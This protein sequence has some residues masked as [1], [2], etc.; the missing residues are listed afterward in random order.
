[1]NEEEKIELINQLNER[2]PEFERK[3]EEARQKL[4][5]NEYASEKEMKEL[6][7]WAYEGFPY[8][9]V[10]ASMKEHLDSI[11]LEEECCPEC[12]GKVVSFYFCSPQWTWS[13]F[14]GRAGDMKICVDC[15]KQFD[16]GFTGSIM[17]N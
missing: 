7:D 13:G 15:G 14:V 6:H 8:T 17:M 16:F 2:I 9:D 4:R 3:E 12:G 1:M 5:K 10:V 11:N